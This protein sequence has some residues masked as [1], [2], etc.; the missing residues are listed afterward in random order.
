MWGWGLGCAAVCTQAWDL[1]TLRKYFQ[2]V[3]TAFNPQ[4][5]PD[6]EAVLRGYYHAQRRAEDRQAARTTL[7]MLNALVRLAQVVVHTHVHRM[8]V[9]Q[10]DACLSTGSCSSDGTKLGDK[11]G[12]SGG[13]VFG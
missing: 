12:C 9:W 6:A 11:A 10:T 5:T 13:S 2:W 1:Q 8:Q 3:R 4:L 7:R